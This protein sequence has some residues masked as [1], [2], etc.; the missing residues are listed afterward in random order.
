MG[1]T[2]RSTGVHLHYEIRVGGRPI[3][4]MNYIRAAQNVF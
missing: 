3:N 4:P 2:G 1:T